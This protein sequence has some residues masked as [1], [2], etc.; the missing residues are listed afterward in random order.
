MCNKTRPQAQTT[1][2]L[3]NHPELKHELEVVS[4][5]AGGTELLGCR[6]AGRKSN[7]KAHDHAQEY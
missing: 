3:Q 2:N 7:R 1:P 5:N 6:I 4:S